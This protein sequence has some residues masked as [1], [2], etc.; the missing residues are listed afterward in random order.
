MA[1]QPG[2][3][4]GQTLRVLLLPLQPLTHAQAPGSHP[5][6]V[7]TP[8]SGFGEGSVCVGLSGVVEEPF[9]CGCY[10]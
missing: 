9:C 5:P 7:P 1:S 3:R 2:H 4:I 6:P 10:F 8:C